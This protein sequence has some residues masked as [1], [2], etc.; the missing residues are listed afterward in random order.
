MSNI[1][2]V[3]EQCG[4]QHDIAHIQVFGSLDTVAAYTFQEK[5]QSLIQSGL[6]RFIID[7]RE[8]EYISSAGIGVFPGMEAAIQTQ[9]GRLL[10][11]YVPEKIHKLFAMIG[12]T[13]MFTMKAT[14]VEALQELDG[15]EQTNSD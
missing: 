11:V 10:F 13:S 2:I 14:F 9:Q 7:L 3:I 1:R 12:L 5:M 15:H 4:R 6:Y 8:L